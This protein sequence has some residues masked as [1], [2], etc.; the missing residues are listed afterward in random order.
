M[1]KTVLWTS[2]LIAALTLIST[3]IAQQ[4]RPVDAKVLRTAGTAKDAMPGA[5]LTYGLTQTEQRYSQLKQIDESN[6]GKLGLA[7][8]APLTTPG[9][10]GGTEG[11]PLMWN[12]TIYQTMDNSIVYALDARTGEQKWMYDAKIDPITPSHMCCGTHNRGLAISDGKLILAANDARL[13]ALDA[14]S[15]KELWQSKVADINQYY[16]ITIAPRIAGD[17]VIIGVGGG[18]YFIRGFFAAYSLKDGKLAWKFH[19]VPPPPGQPFEDKAQ[20]DAAKTWTGEW[21]KYGGG[22]AVWDGLV[23][24]PELN[25]VIAGVG[26]PEPWP[27]EMR[28]MTKE[29]WAKFANL[30]TNSIVA[31]DAKTGKLKWYYQTVP[32]DAWDLDAVGGFIMADIQIDGKARK[33]V[34]QAPK[35]GVFYIID[36]TNG[37]FI[38]AEPFV[39]INWATSFDKKN[40]GRPVINPDAFYDQNKAVMIYPGG[41]GAHNWAPMS[42]NPNAGLVYLPYTAGSYNFVAAPEPNPKAGGGAHGLGFGGGKERQTPMPIWGPDN[43]GRGGLQARDPKTNQIKWVKTGRGGNIGG[44]TLTTASNLVFQTAGTTLY[45]YKA[46]TGDELLAVPFN[47]GGPAPPITYMV[48]NTQYVGFATRT[49]FLAM[50]VGGTEKMPDAPPPAGFGRGKGDPKAAPAPPPPDAGKELHGQGKQ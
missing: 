22:G 26:N 32:N 40:N 7:W 44:G 46:D 50:K 6:I 31:V 48:D 11:T 37:Q 12:N 42:Y 21:A 5:W 45:A 8:S 33:V 30:Y 15:G 2:A 18:E 39:P 20:E 10:R 36:R 24:D 29:N 41:G 38:S 35:S 19:T 3:I 13:I 14:I 43:V 47:L 1:K 4:P 28:G 27:V 23:Y 49:H 25:L 17:N 16:S 9:G 34:M